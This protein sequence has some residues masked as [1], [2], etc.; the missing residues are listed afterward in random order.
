MALEIMRGIVEAEKNADGIKAEALKEAENLKAE[1]VRRSN[2]ILAS[3]KKEAKLVE[4][5]LI[6]KAVAS[7]QPKI[8]E[9]LSEADSQCKKIKETA[10]AKKSEAVKAVLGRVVGDDGNC[11]NE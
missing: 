1:T 5:E 11:S 4:E 8:S 9:I 2:E 3:A 10:G 7:S 6:Q